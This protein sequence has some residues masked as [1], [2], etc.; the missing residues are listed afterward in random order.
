MVL[1]FTPRFAFM[2]GAWNFSTLPAMED[3]LLTGKNQPSKDYD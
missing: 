1:D 2:T 3:L